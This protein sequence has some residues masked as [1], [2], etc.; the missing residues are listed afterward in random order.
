[1]G[2]DMDESKIRAAEYEAQRA[3]R[4]FSLRGS[5]QSRLSDEELD[6]ALSAARDEQAKRDAARMRDLLR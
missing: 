2:D 4:P 3:T 1:M 6:A 5:I